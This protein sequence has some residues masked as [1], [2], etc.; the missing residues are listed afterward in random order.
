MKRTLALLFAC[1]FL[2]CA[3]GTNSSP[4]QTQGGKT[5]ETASVKETSAAGTT[6]PATA[7]TKE[8]AVKTTEEKPTATE[9]KETEPAT[10]QAPA[11]TEEALPYTLTAH[12]DLKAD[13]IDYWASSDMDYSCFILKRN[14]LYGS[15]DADGKTVTAPC[16]SNVG[17]IWYTL[18]T[19]DQY[20]NKIGLFACNN[21]FVGDEGYMVTSDGQFLPDVQYG[22]GL[23][24]Y[25]KAYWTDEGVK[26]I[27]CEDMG[28]PQVLENFE[29]YKYV[30]L[31][32]NNFI[33]GY[34]NFVSFADRYTVIPV[35]CALGF[36]TKDNY[37]DTVVIPNLVSE[38]YGLLDVG[39]QNMLT[40]F[41][42]DE[43]TLPIDGVIGVRIGNKV[44]YRAIYGEMITKVDLAPGNA[45]E[46][47][48]WD[49]ETG[50][51]TKT[52]YD[53]YTPVNG[54]IVTV[55][56]GK[57]GLIDSNGKEILENRFEYLSQV[58]R[59]GVFWAK[60][61]GVWYRGEMAP[62]SK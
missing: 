28:E 22:F 9:T 47:S 40:D 46:G 14:G 10:T 42:Y 26:M 2:L 11:E 32:Q 43:C 1:L 16:A 57:F 23:G 6:A 39:P 45:Y 20:S 21:A 12:E 24:S 38:K 17:L 37:G 30:R 29:Y 44:G 53:L 48:A 62:K 58:G 13:T 56:N 31:N 55:K 49:E 52:Y 34:Q 8:T 3:C 36:T 7:E 25:A 15:I 33:G 50:E 54:Y 60:E 35:Q 5:A 59:G 41:L 51:Y 18:G 61:N 19:H 4:A 27:T